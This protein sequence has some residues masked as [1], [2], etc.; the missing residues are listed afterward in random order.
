MFQG[1][2]PKYQDNIYGIVFPRSEIPEWFSHQ[3]M[4]DEVNIMEPFSHL[5]KE[6]I[7]IA[8]CVVFCSHSHHQIYREARP[9]CKLTINGKYWNFSPGLGIIDVLSDHIWLCYCLPPFSLMEDEKSLWE[10]DTN[11]F[12]EIG[13]VVDEKDRKSTRLNSSHSDSSR[14]PSSA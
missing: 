6:W 12:C 13:I 5:C 14:M 3:C 9:W 10:C 11:G 2:S 7:G 1:L 8:F 4:G